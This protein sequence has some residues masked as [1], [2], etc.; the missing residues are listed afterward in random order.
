MLEYLLETY[1]CVNCEEGDT[2]FD[3]FLSTYVVFMQ[4]GQITST[5]LSIYKARPQQRP[6]DN[7]DL[8]LREKVKV[9][10]FVL[11]W[12][13]SSRETFSED[14]KIAAFLDV[15]ILK[16]LFFQEK[17]SNIFL[18]IE[19]TSK[20]HPNRFKT[21]STTERRNQIDRIDHRK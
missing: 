18:H 14:P 19:G 3:D 9:I 13:D 12:H 8:T 4:T 11:E 1:M 16:K 6:G 7:I 5:L 21:L 15:K 10:R 2:S 20:C 17:S